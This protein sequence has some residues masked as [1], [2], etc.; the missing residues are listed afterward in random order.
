MQD[1]CKALPTVAS[2]LIAFHFPIDVYLIRLPDLMSVLRISLNQTWES[3]KDLFLS[4]VASTLLNV[5]G[6][7]NS[8]PL[9]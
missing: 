7:R 3:V 9:S 8:I 2:F 5:D 6:G 4:A 1:R